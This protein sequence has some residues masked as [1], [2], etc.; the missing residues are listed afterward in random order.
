MDMHTFEAP[1]R[2]KANTIVTRDDRRRLRA[3]C[4]VMKVIYHADTDAAELD[5]GEDM[6]EILMV[7]DHPVFHLA[8]HRADRADNLAAK[9]PALDG[10]RKA[11]M[12]IIMIER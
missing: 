4:S 10:G 12:L 8:Y 5:D 1:E 9:A 2:H 7:A 3:A 11:D 6:I